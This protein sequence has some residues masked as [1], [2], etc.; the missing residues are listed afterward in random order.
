MP[1]PVVQCSRGQKY[2][3]GC[4]YFRVTGLYS[5]SHWQGRSRIDEVLAF[6]FLMLPGT[7]QT[8][9]FAMKF[10]IAKLTLYKQ[11]NKRTTG[12]AYGKT[13]YID[14]GILFMPEQVPEGDFQVVSDHNE[15]F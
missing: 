15:S 1:V 7:V 11:H 10:I 12:D 2:P 6:I 5:R 3:A 4:R 14:S 8:V 9:G 13:E